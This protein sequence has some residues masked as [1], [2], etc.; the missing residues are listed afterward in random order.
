M[1]VTS[2]QMQIQSA[3]IV[4]RRYNLRRTSLWQPQPNGVLSLWA[5][6]GAFVY[7]PPFPPSSP[8]PDAAFNRVQKRHLDN[9]LNLYRGR[10]IIK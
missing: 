1:F 5:E 7:S 10:N 9:L 4:R 8:N 2:L 3:M 6:A